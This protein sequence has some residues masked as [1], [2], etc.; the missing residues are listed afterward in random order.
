MLHLLD[1]KLQLLQGLVALIVNTQYS[2]HVQIRFISQL[3]NGMSSVF[4]KLL[5][6]FNSTAI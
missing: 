6:Y 3:I 4:Q 5:K 2:D 1:N